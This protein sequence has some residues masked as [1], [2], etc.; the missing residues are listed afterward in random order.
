[1]VSKLLSS[2]WK[3]PSSS[4]RRE[5]LDSRCCEELLVRGRSSSSSRGQIWALLSSETSKLSSEELGEVL[6]AGGVSSDTSRL[7][8]DTRMESQL[9]VE[10]GAPFEWSEET[11]DLVFESFS[12]RFEF[13]SSCSDSE[14]SEEKS[15]SVDLMTGG[16]KLS[17]KSSLLMD[18]WSQLYQ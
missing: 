9:T 15:S 13:T 5:L 2:E 6:E 14:D 7:S 3:E 12:S 16:S 1:M 11:V 10:A 17:L 18:P 8:S 4:S